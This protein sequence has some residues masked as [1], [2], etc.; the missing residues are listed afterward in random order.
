MPR[1]I[2]CLLL[3]ASTSLASAQDRSSFSRSSG[4]SPTNE[5]R[6]AYIEAMRSRDSR[7]KPAA[8]PVAGQPV[9]LSV[10]IVALEGDVEFREAAQYDLD[11]FQG[12]LH[13][14]KK[15]GHVK[16]AEQYRIST[17]ENLQATVQVGRSLA[18]PS[19]QSTGFSRGRDGQPVRQTQYQQRE[20]GTIVAATA[21]IDSDS[22]V[23]VQIQ[24]EQSLLET[25]EPKEGE[26][27]VLPQIN[28]L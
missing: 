12:L 24:V 7:S 17:L 1:L 25:P 15:S 28:T 18:V 23:I 11:E 21:R 20:T 5:Q 19:G 3:I 22:S 13:D 16:H 9:S 26:E 4:S 27:L 10:F 2:C 6:E 14:W 8:Q